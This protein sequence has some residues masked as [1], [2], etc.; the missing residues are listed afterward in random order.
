MN[1][2]HLSL[3]VFTLVGIFMFSG[4]RDKMGKLENPSIPRLLLEPRGV[5]YGSP[6]SGT[7]VLE[8]PTT[9]TEYVV[10][11]NP[12]INEFEILNAEMVK[13]DLGVAL[14]LRLS[15]RGARALYRAS[16]TNMG[17]VVVL[18]I[19]DNP[20]GARRLDGAIADGTFYTF[21]ELPEDELGQLVLDIKETI[22]QLQKSK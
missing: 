7:R 14:M 16:V 13:V 20:I 15:D 2:A 1:K 19:N 12:L 10:S 22:I 8:L 3:L 5:N 6:A 4:C 11:A 18:T 17:S 21:V 9:G